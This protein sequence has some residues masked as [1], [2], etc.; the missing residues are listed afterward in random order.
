MP[1]LSSLTTVPAPARTGAPV[2]LLAMG[3]RDEPPHGAV[4]EHLERA[5]AVPRSAPMARD[6]RTDHL[7][8]IVSQD[9]LELCRL[10]K[11]TARREWLFFLIAFL[12]VATTVWMLAHLRITILVRDWVLAAAGEKTVPHGK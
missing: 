11:E 5:T 8:S 3:E 2:S 6:R 10:E 7:A 12:R 9:F 1:L 4:L